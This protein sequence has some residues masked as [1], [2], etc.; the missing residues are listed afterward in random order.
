VGIMRCV[1]DTNIIIDL[2][3]K[4]PQ[5]KQIFE[6]NEIV[7]SKITWIEVVSGAKNAAELIQLKEFLGNFE[8][9]GLNDE[10]AELAALLRIER[11][12]KLPDAIIY[13]TA[14]QAKL[15]L[16]TRDEKGF[17]AALP[18]VKIPYKL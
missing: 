10:I 11:K 6:E 4:K 8:I 7:I 1:V 5:A 9:I 3:S 16:L 14:K 12:M 15:T 18:D 2:L 13:A 17:D